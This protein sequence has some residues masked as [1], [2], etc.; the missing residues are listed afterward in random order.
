MTSRKKANV[1]FDGFNFYYGCVKDTP[2]RWLDLGKLCRM[3]LPEFQINRIRY[4]TARVQAW[5]DDPGQPQRQLTY[6]R[7]LATIPNLSI[8][9][10]QFTVK[11]KMRRLADPQPPGGPRFARVLIP[12]EKGSDV[13]LATYLLIDGFEQDYEVAVVVSNDSDLLLPIQMVRDKLGL[14]VGVIN[15][16]KNARPSLQQAADFYRT[17][18]DGVLRSSHFPPTLADAH[19]TITKPAAW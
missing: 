4:F 12:E 17:V 2:H 8:H 18:R 11:P 14:Q 9:Y 10:G 1:Y 5:P 3:V 16:Y 15:P 19:G 13:N 7:A 6:L